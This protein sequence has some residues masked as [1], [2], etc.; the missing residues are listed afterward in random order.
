MGRERGGQGRS[1]GALVQACGGTVE[2]GAA[3]WAGEL[4]LR[5]KAEL[6]CGGA[7]GLA[8]HAAGGASGG[9]GPELGRVWVDREPG[10]CALISE[11]AGGEA[12]QGRS[13]AGI[14]K[15]R[16]SVDQEVGPALAGHGPALAGV[17]ALAG[18]RS[19]FSRFGLF[20]ENSGRAVRRFWWNLEEKNVDSERN[21]RNWG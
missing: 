21:T 10:A 8:R 4:A 9:A 2:G 18:L 19:G 16:G 15:E 11:E 3:T 13:D 6:G 20:R 5:A 12:S 17:P 7:K 14:A 1:A